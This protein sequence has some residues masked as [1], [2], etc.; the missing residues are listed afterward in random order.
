MPKRLREELLEIIQNSDRAC[1]DRG[2]AIVELVKSGMRQVEIA[3]STELSTVAISHLKK[4]SENLKGKAREMCKDRKMNSDACYTLAS[5]PDCDQERA[6]GRAIQL[7]KK[8]D[9]Q[10][11]AQHRGSKGRQTLRG[12]ITDK[13]MK[14]AIMEIEKAE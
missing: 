6:L 2:A 8:K 7:R 12:Q 1:V 10:R 5:A 11:S 3:G 4:C 14:E 9:D 13:D